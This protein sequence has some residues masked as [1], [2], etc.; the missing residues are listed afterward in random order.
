MQ[1]EHLG[2]P[3]MGW[4]PQRGAGHSSM[5]VPSAVIVGSGTF[6]N[7]EMNFRPSIR[8]GGE[9]VGSRRRRSLNTISL[10]R[11]VQ[12]ITRLCNKKVRGTKPI[13]EY[14]NGMKKKH[15]RV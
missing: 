1:G 14:G 6:L 5:L 8:S 7:L 2:K 4:W 11:L 12:E 3:G 10:C 9:V 13:F 15:I